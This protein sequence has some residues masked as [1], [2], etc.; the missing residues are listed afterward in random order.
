MNVQDRI[1]ALRKRMS[2]RSNDERLIAD[3]LTSSGKYIIIII[4]V[5][6]IYIKPTAMNINYLYVH[7]TSNEVLCM[8]CI[9]FLCMY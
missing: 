7:M 1:E 8:S 4:I 6:I 3:Q 5:I 2:G 9:M